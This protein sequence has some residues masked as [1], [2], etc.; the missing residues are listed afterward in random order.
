MICFRWNRHHL[1]IAITYTRQWLLANFMQPSIRNE[2]KKEPLATLKIRFWKK[3]HVL[4]A[5]RKKTW[6]IYTIL[7][8]KRPIHLGLLDIVLKYNIGNLGKKEESDK[9][10]GIKWAVMVVEAGLLG[11]RHTLCPENTSHTKALT[12]EGQ[13]DSRY[14]TTE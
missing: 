11:C 6:S 4:L 7:R 10:I 3:C 9:E 8:T 14:L 13:R 5:E 1:C 2:L 12:S